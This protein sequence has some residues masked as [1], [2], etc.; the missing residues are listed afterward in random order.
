M[1]YELPGRFIVPLPRRKHKR[2]QEQFINTT[3]FDTPK[4]GNVE[5]IFSGTADE[6][7]KTATSQSTADASSAPASITVMPPSAGSPPMLEAGTSAG[8]RLILILAVVLLVA[9]AGGA[10]Y[11]YFRVSKIERP[12]SPE[13]TPAEESSPV[14]VLPEPQ[15]D[16]PSAPS[17]PIPSVPVPIIEPVPEPAAIPPD[18]D[19][20]GLTD[21]EETALGTNNNSVDSDFDGLFDYEE[22]KVYLTNPNNADTDGDGFVDGMELRNGYNPN[23]PGKLQIIPTAPR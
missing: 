16:L 21:A 1:Q 15:G 8:R 19:H 17:E 18:A 4:P 9:L 14:P 5:D 22:V 2:K 20:D 3:M 11:W 6:M 12:S 10:A 23:G 13:D 7:A